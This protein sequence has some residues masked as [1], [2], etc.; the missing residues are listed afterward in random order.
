[1]KH[2]SP[3]RFFRRGPLNLILQDGWPVL[4]VN[5]G[6]SVTFTLGFVFKRY[7][8]MRLFVR[9]WIFQMDLGQRPK[10][11]DAWQ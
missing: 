9:G 1:M 6:Q 11:W 4:V 10:S 5:E 3:Y 2:R 7:F 8:E